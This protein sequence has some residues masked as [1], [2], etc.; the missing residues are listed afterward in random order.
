[1]QSQRPI[2]YSFALAGELSVWCRA[3]WSLV[4]VDSSALKS[5][6]TSQRIHRQI[7]LSAITR[8]FLKECTFGD[9]CRILITIVTDDSVETMETQNQDRRSLLKGGL[10][11]TALLSAGSITAGLTGCS[12]SKPAQNDTFL[13]AEDKLLFAALAPVILKGAI[14]SEQPLPDQILP[15]IDQACLALGAH[16][17]Q[18]VYKLFDLLS[19][20]VTRWAVAGV[21]SSWGEASEEE[22]T[23]FL[24][25]WKNSR[26]GLLNAGYRLLVKLVAVSFYVTEESRKISGYPGPQPWAKAA[27]WQ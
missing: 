20:G 8:R 17:Q 25:S 12:S 5:P 23:E 9:E 6:A 21:S 4:N 10:F 26:W 1:M 15:G 2:R 7:G 22:I 19:L 18:E 27:L 11:G 24:D 13:R 16:S 3:F 14:S